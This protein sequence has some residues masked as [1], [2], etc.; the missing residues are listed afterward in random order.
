MFQFKKFLQKGYYYTSVRSFF[1]KTLPTAVTGVKERLRWHLLKSQVC[2]MTQF[3]VFILK[4]CQR[5]FSENEVLERNKTHT[6]KC[7]PSHVF[8]GAVL[9]L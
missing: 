3:L 2:F 8:Q 5:N 7:A 4:A 9:L 1:D 6:Y